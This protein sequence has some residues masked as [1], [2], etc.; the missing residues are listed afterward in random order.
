MDMI[1]QIGKIGFVLT[2][3]ASAAAWILGIIFIA[4]AV[5][6]YNVPDS[7]AKIT[8]SAEVEVDMDLTEANLDSTAVQTLQEYLEAGEGGASIGAGSIVLYLTEYVATEVGGNGTFGGELVS[9]SLKDLYRV[10]LIGGI[11]LLLTV[12]MLVFNGFF[13]KAL[14]DAKTPFDEKLGTTSTNF[15]YIL[16]I[17]GLLTAFVLA[18][19]KGMF[20]GVIK[21]D[22]AGIIIIVLTLF[23]FF[24]L[25]VMRMMINYQK[26]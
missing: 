21:V 16:I 4:M 22:V 24:F 3:I 19:I 2:I 10:P 12:G 18:T 6:V 15:S 14:R 13:A 20:T 8:T 1:H 7:L 26:A 9:L 17:W 5:M 25:R 23:I 11:Y